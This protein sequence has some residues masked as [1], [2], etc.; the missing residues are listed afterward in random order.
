MHKLLTSITSGLTFLLLSL[1][2]SFS[3]D[4]ICE[5]FLEG[6]FIGTTPEFPGVKWK[7][8]RND[9]YQVESILEIPNKYLE[10]GYP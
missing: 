6:T 4:L 10:M 1:N 5:D 8:V 2:I 3:Q 9:N 7:I